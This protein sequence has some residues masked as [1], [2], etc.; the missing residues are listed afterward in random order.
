MNSNAKGLWSVE[1]SDSRITA[2]SASPLPGLASTLMFGV[3]PTV[4]VPPLSSVDDVRGWLREVRFRSFEVG[5]E[6]VWGS[7][8]GVVGILERG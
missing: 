6:A 2:C 3:E 7:A 1:S 8:D 4:L 5:A